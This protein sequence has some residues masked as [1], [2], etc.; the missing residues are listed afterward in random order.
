MENLN[1]KEF[2]PEN[3]VEK[4]IKDAELRER[5]IRNLLVKDDYVRFNSNKVLLVLSEKA[6]EILY[7]DWDFFAKLLRSTNNFHIVIGIQLLAN[8]V[9]VDN[10][11]KFERLFDEYCGLIDAKSVMT[12]SHL[13]LNL[14]KIAKVKPNLREKVT[15]TLLSID[16]T[17]HE[18]QRKELVKASVIQSFDEYFDTIEDKVEVINFVKSQLRSQSPKTRKLAKSFLKRRE[19]K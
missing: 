9:K 17:H 19:I 16:K 18:P 15:K 8:L 10:K 14:G 12:A 5:L 7:P 1:K 3:L 11:A 2:K 6:P 4:A 13:A